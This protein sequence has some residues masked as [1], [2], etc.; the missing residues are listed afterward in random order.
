M[1]GGTPRKPD[2]PVST[3]STLVARTVAPEV[4]T[5]VRPTAKTPALTCAA[6]RIR[7]CSP[8]CVYAAPCSAPTHLVPSTCEHSPGRRGPSIGHHLPALWA[9]ANGNHAEGSL[10][11]FLRV[12]TVREST[13]TASWPV[14]RLLLVRLGTMPA[15]A[16]RTR[17]LRLSMASHTRQS[18]G[19]PERHLAEALRADRGSPR[20][21]PPICSLWDIAW[22]ARV[23][24]RMQR[25]R[26]LGR[27]PQFCSRAE[28]RRRSRVKSYPR[29]IPKNPPR[30]AE[31]PNGQP[32]HAS[33][34]RV[35]SRA[36]ATYNAA[37]HATSCFGSSWTGVEADAR[38]AAVLGGR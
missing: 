19:Y 29:A 30:V 17:G 36:G 37:S 3:R 4:L 16:T 28:H 18:P 13:A 27:R 8:S 22:E 21:L 9:R 1:V 15:E 35:D 10:P 11:V 12:R 32:L 24:L 14:L 23:F 2:H 5:W 33:R 31:S 38:N 25:C 7:A 20:L 26:V 34:P 6:R